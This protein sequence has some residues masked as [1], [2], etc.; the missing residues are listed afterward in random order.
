MATIVKEID[1]VLD[2]EQVWK[3]I[4]ATSEVNELVG[5]VTEC[6]LEGDRRFCTFADGAQITEVILSVD[7]DLRRVA[8]SVVE[9]P[10][11][12]EY[13]AASMQ[14]FEKDSGAKIVWTV[15]LKPDGMAETMDGFL[16][17][18]ADSLQEGLDKRKA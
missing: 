5:M 10:F 14:V 6:R 17:Q 16:Q 1:S 8:Y 7:E 13:H 18:A 2:S 9:N 11:G 3:A 15:D 12:I 4:A